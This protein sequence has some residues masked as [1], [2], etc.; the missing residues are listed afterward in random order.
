MKVKIDTTPGLCRFILETEEEDLLEPTEK[1][2]LDSKVVEIHLPWQLDPDSIHPDHLALCIMMITHPFVGKALTFPKP[3]SK[4]FSDFHHSKSSRYTIGPIDETL[5]PWSPSENS[6]PGLAFSGGV[7][8]TAALALMPPTTAPIFM[9]RP[10]RKKSLYDK[11]AVHY[12][13]LEVERLGYDMH[14]ILC[15]LEYVRSPVGFPVDVANSVPAVLMAE[16]LNLDCI[17][18]GTIM[19][20]TYGTGHRR[21]RDYPNGHHYTLWGGLFKAAG[22]PFILPVAGISEVGTS[23]IV[24]KAPLGSLSQSCMRGTWKKPCLNCWKCF[25]KQLLD[26]AI[27]GNQLDSNYLNDIFNNKEA[28]L[29]L[30][31]VPIKHENILTWSTHRLESEHALFKLLKDR[32]RGSE[33]ALDWLGKW[34]SPSIELMP[35]KYRSGVKEKILRYLSIMDLE[36]EKK[37]ISWNMNTLIESDTVAQQSESLTNEMRAALKP[38]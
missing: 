29:F 15:D 19:E 33:D 21:Y 17:G 4:R 16:Y 30:A 26:N 35:E 13:C 18:F 20:S 31:R 23:M 9:D 11:D 22:L 36:D 24:S 5:E 2:S 14:V 34:Y 38:R 3:V 8:S 25:R 32:V 28:C 1:V 10:I 7:D 37:L 27:I 6:R 12:S